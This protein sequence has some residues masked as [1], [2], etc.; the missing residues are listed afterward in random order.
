M[1]I[2]WISEFNR[3]A[4]GLLGPCPK[5]L[6]ER[7]KLQ[8]TA[9]V[10]DFRLEM[11]PSEN[12]DENPKIWWFINGYHVIL[13][14]DWDIEHK[15]DS[16]ILGLRSCLL[17]DTGS[18]PGVGPSFSCPGSCW[19]WIRETPMISNGNP[20]KSWFLKR[21]TPKSYEG[22]VEWETNGFRV[23]RNSQ[24][25]KWLSGGWMRLRL[26]IWLSW[27]FLIPASVSGMVR[28]E[29][30]YRMLIGFPSS[31]VS[32]LSRMESIPCLQNKPLT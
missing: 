21:G 5:R 11:G 23:P 7:S 24:T 10:M 3:P 27:F 16:H 14:G 22:H 15:P 18:R 28:T 1:H 17:A 12:L 8:G 20:S 29:P 2:P 30:C 13:G 32:S 31:P 25:L 26:Y 6:K 19:S 9:G 4:T